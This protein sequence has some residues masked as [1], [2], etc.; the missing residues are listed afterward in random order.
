MKV[1][2]LDLF[3]QH[4][5]LLPQMI[6]TFKA[7]VESSR[8]VLGQTVETF[9]SQLTD[10]CAAAGAVG[11]SS[12]TDALLAALM[13]LEI[14]PGD[15]VITTPF[16]FFATAGGIA[17]VGATPVFV[18][19]EAESFNLDPAGIEAAITSRTRAIIPVH[20]YGL[21]ADMVAICTLAKRHDLKVI[22]DFAQA[23]G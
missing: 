20:L 13:A 14:G 9:E 1:P 6:D 22:E 7:V 5:P 18:D 2:P 21:M 11:V 10:Y 3:C 23:F 17:R 19:I 12:G 4:E 16:T 8:F 15:E